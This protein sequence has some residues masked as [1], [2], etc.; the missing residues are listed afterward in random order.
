MVAEQGTRRRDSARAA[1]NA[2]DE[3]Q[4]EHVLQLIRVETKLDGMNSRV[5][6]IEENLA[7]VKDLLMQALDG[8]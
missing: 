4:R 7:E 3:N 1:A 2:L 5:R 8:R 6:S